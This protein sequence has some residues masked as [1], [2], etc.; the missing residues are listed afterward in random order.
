MARTFWPILLLLAACSFL[1]VV[2]LIVRS[3]LPRVAVLDRVS[4][5]GWLEG[6]LPLFLALPLAGLTAA[7]AAGGAPIAAATA[8]ALLSPSLAALVALSLHLLRRRGGQPTGTEGAAAERGPAGHVLLWCVT[9]LIL[10]LLAASDQ[11][12][13]WQGQCLLTGAIILFWY[14]LPDVSR[15]GLRLVDG[16]HAAGLTGATP[17]LVGALALLAAVLTWAGGAGLT[18][19]LGLGPGLGGDEAA[20][21]M[22]LAGGTLMLVAALAA[23]VLVAPLL[24]IA[25]RLGARGLLAAG[26]VTSALTCWLALGGWTLGSMAAKIA[27]TSGPWG[28]QA[29]SLLSQFMYDPRLWYPVN[30]LG[31]TAFAAVTLLAAPLLFVALRTEAAGRMLA[32]L[33]G[34][35]AALAVLG[36]AFAGA[37]ALLAGL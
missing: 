28:Q 20:G 12:H 13:I 35:L 24:A 19:G 22:R 10:L 33:A 32:I 31:R 4:Q 2:V 16:N 14:G 5:R 36:L 34:L 11:L 21:S 1:A 27:P 17:L 9:G 7:S 37:V 26:A 15:G 23:A 6:W 3:L 30:G 8:P 18:A 29:A 25:G